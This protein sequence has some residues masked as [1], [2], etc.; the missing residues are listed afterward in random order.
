MLQME[1]Q[2]SIQVVHMQNLFLLA[3]SFQSCSTHQLHDVVEVAQ[4]QTH[5]YYSYYQHCSRERTIFL[6]LQLKHCFL[7]SLAFSLLGVL[8]FQ[9]GYW[10][11]MS[12]LRPQLPVER[13]ALPQQKQTR[14]LKV[15]KRAPPP[16]IIKS[17]LKPA[18][19]EI[20]PSGVNKSCIMCNYRQL[21][22]LVHYQVK[23]FFQRK[24]FQEYLLRNPPLHL[25]VSLIQQFYYGK[26][27][28]TP[29]HTVLLK[30]DKVR[31][32]TICF[33]LCTLIHLQYH[34]YC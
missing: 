6:A 19:Y 4:P 18:Q 14:E 11:F 3:V 16:A 26:H 28:K 5:F 29:N 8:R 2:Q 25:N 12:R 20:S 9:K 15:T 23:A 34:Q 10:G 1:Q 33:Q 21:W 27:H 22:E 24:P 17:S 7:L 13:V 30:V 32:Q 31:N